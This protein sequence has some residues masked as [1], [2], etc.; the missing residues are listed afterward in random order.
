MGCGYIHSSE[1]E[2]WAR[3]NRMKIGRTELRALKTIDRAFVIFQ[4]EKDKPPPSKPGGLFKQL[5]AMSAQD[6]NRN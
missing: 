2:A 6:K 3:L 1:Y 5:V 4:N